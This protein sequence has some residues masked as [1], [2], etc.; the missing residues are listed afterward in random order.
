MF[1]LD[2][3]S[4]QSRMAYTGCGV[5]TICGEEDAMAGQRTP[6]LF[7]DLGTVAR[8]YG[9]VF[10]MFGQRV[11]RGPDWEEKLTEEALGAYAPGRTYEPD[12]ALQRHN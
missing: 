7:Q 6:T 2:T 1:L 5:S 3:F 10:W 12:P 4:G 8:L 9:T 11:K